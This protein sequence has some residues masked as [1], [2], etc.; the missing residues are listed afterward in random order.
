MKRI[1][2]LSL[3]LALTLIF[4]AC[5]E[6]NGNSS[7]AD[8]SSL[9]SQITESKP[10]STSSA[11]QST[12]VPEETS[13]TGIR[14]FPVV[15]YP[16]MSIKASGELEE[17]LKPLEEFGRFYAT[18]LFMDMYQN[19][20]FDEKPE[21][22]TEETTENG[23]TYNKTFTKVS[24]CGITTYSA[25]TEKLN[26]L[27]TEKCLEDTAREIRDRFRAG[28]NGEL[29]VAN[30]GAGGYLGDSYLRLNKISRSDD[31]TMIL[32]M[33][34]IGEAEEWGYEQDRV[35]D[36]SITLKRTSG[37]LKIDEFGGEK[38]ASHY[39]FYPLTMSFLKYNNVFLELDNLTEFSLSKR[40]E[41]ADKP[42]R[43]YRPLNETEEIIKL[44]EDHAKPG[45]TPAEG[46]RLFFDSLE[47]PDEN[48]IRVKVSSR[49]VHEDGVWIKA[50]AE[51]TRTSDGLQLKAYDPAILDFFAYY[52]EILI[53]G[54]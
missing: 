8:E 26:S 46:S 3:L 52:P 19:Y 41:E 9:I 6:N 16:K 5:S 32:D 11:A 27:L 23:K 2:A 43:Y 31:K 51:F 48:T 47:Y 34:V 13:D 14:E 24:K 53:E 21:R 54:Q 35:D 7:E 25:M 40:A 37:G 17:A 39:D 15:I 33:S 45:E 29:F 4:T 20:L 42:N 44:L 1:K 50:T 18:Y 38:Y 49:D 28:E 10:Q 12:S 36:F 22:F 30:T